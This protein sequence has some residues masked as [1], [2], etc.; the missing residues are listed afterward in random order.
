CSVHLFSAT[1]PGS[2]GSTVVSEA[3]LSQPAGAR[4]LLRCQSLRM[5][6]TQDRLNDRQRVVH[7]DLSGGPGSPSR[8]LLDM[9]SAGEQRVYASRDRSRLLLAPSAFQ[10]GN[11]SLIIRSV[12]EQDEGLY[13]CNLHHHYCHLYETLAIRL[14]V[15]DD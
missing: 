9:Y 4:A 14:Q 15:T 11:F 13:T 2:G 3:S 12:E 1:S 8:R 6:W 5:V 10:D 7:W